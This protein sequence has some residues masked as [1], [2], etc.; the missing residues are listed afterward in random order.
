MN[1]GFQEDD[2]GQPRQYFAG[3]VDI[4]AD[5]RYPH[6]HTLWSLDPRNHGDTATF[7]RAPWFDVS[8]FRERS[9]IALYESGGRLP[10]NFNVSALNRPEW[11][12]RFAIPLRDMVRRH[13]VNRTRM[14]DADTATEYVR[15]LYRRMG[16][17]F[18]GLQVPP[19]MA[20]D[21]WYFRTAG[22]EAYG[23]TLA[24]LVD[25]VDDYVGQTRPR[26]E[27]LYLGQQLRAEFRF[28]D[29]VR[30]MDGFHRQLKWERRARS[31]FGYLV[32]YQ[33]GEIERMTQRA[34][35]GRFVNLPMHWQ[36]YEIPQGFYC[37]L[38]PVLT[39]LGSK[40]INRPDSG[41]W[42]I[43]YTEWVAKLAATFLWVAYDSYELWC[44][45]PAVCEGMKSLSLGSV[46]G[47]PHNAEDMLD[48]LEV[49]EQTNWEEVPIAQSRRSTMAN[50]RSPGRNANSG[51]FIYF[52]PWKREVITAEQAQALKRNRPEMP[53]DHR[54]GMYYSRVPDPSGLNPLNMP[55]QVVG[56]PEGISETSDGEGNNNAQDESAMVD[57]PEGN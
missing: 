30:H 49:V 3:S 19:E 42:T 56:C 34:R 1:N 22:E 12:L 7:A 8:G 4:A 6:P 44:L 41:F 18:P 21:T 38:P 32:P 2:Y 40:M 57:G 51:D 37:E 26:D 28:L 31:R 10:D 36:D 24:T 23:V 39:Y 15:V 20:F 16:R 53:D 9:L 43:F 46:L 17:F 50:I 35:E 11:A 13:P 27:V 14:S 54:V 48:L 25:H 29:R 47:N 5:R 55:E 45:P 52:D 33:N